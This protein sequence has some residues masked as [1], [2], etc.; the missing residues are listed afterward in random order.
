MDAHCCLDALFEVTTFKAWHP[1][2]CCCTIGLAVPAG[3]FV[4]TVSK[5]KVVSTMIERYYHNA[6]RDEAKK[7]TQI[8]LDACGGSCFGKIL[9]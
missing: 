1:P 5:R 3:K 6:K 9:A 8:C 2:Q 4:E 7:S